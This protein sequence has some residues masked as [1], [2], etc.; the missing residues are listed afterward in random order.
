MTSSSTG[1][2]IAG[3][4]PVGLTLAIALGRRGVRCTVVESKASHALLP[5]MELLNPRS[6]EIYRRLGIEPAIRQ[7]G[8]PMDAPMDVVVTT[9]LNETPIHRMPY[10]S[11]RAMEIRIAAT[12]DGTEARSAYQRISQYTLEPLLRSAAEALDPVTVRFGTCLDRFTQTPSGVDADIIDSTGRRERVMATHLVGCDG[13]GSTVRQ[14]L[15]IDLEGRSA[16]SRMVHVFFRCDDLLDRHPLGVAR[17]T[18]TSSVTSRP[19]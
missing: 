15:A 13:G 9:S 4:G 19:A 10:P 11:T 14:Q 2:L 1:V 6:M 7:A 3:G 16:V 12:H 18:T 5:K 8:Y 17:A